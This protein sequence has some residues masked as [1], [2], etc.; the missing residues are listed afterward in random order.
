M[1]CRRLRRR[2]AGDRT[3]QY[4][5]VRSFGGAARDCPSALAPPSSNRGWP[6]DLGGATAG[7]GG[8]HQQAS[9]ALHPDTSHAHPTT[10]G[11]EGRGLGLFDGW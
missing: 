6:C 9:P 10:T 1:F 4:I 8:S 11:I 5:E 3:S 2:V 7:C